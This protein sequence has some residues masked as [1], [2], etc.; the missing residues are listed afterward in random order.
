MAPYNF[1]IVVLYFFNFFNSK[2]KKVFINI[3]YFKWYKNYFSLVMT[4]RV[5]SSQP[6][7]SWAGRA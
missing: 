2:Y 1:I 6:A 4:K 3:Y 5:G 7:K